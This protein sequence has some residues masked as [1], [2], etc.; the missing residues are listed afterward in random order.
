[1]RLQTKHSPKN[2]GVHSRH[3][4]IGFCKK[5]RGLLRPNL[6]EK[7]VF[8]KFENYIVLS[9]GTGHGRHFLV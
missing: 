3:K 8:S 7:G 9:E 1:M 4:K 2:I 5:G 6:C